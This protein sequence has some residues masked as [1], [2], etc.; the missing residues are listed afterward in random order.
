[1]RFVTTP[2][3]CTQRISLGR[4]IAQAIQEKVE[5]AAG[6]VA[7][8]G[9]AGDEGDP[10]HAEHHVGSVDIA[11]KLPLRGARLQQR[12]NGLEQA[13][14][15]LGE[16]VAPRCDHR[17][18]S[19]GH[20]MFGGQVV[21]EAIHP[22]PQCHV[23]RR[24]LQ[25]LRNAGAE[26]RQLVAVGGFDERLTGWEMAVQRADAHACVSSDRLQRHVGTVMREGMDGDLEQ[27][28][29]VALG[30]GSQR[31]GLGDRQGGVLRFSLTNGAASGYP[32]E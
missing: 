24:R 9:R 16:W 10:A 6:L 8:F 4:P 31:A 14:A 21:D 18:Q 32:V 5:Q 23:G 13:F 20:P 27:P 22:G 26:P 29:A 28:V 19:L 11:S 17:S 15:T 2:L 25:Q 3:L 12:V 7:L 1:M 30:I